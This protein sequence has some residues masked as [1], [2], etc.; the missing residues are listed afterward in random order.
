MK[1]Q[2]LFA[3]AAGLIAVAIR[4]LG[5]APLADLAALTYLT[6]ATLTFGPSVSRSDAK[7][8]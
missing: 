5:P 4:A 2:L 7:E 1:S 6:T 3:A 8:R